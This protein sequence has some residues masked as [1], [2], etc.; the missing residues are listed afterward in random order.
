MSV[1]ALTRAIL[2]LICLFFNK[3]GYITFFSRAT[4]LANTDQR[5]FKMHAYSAVSLRTNSY[6]PGSRRTAPYR[7]TPVG[8]PRPSAKLRAAFK[9]TKLA[10]FRRSG[11]CFF[12][13]RI[14]RLR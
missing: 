9:T 10:P 14:H 3:L 1:N 11:S 12:F 4:I 6:Q 2:T 7:F 13:L 5:Y 8:H